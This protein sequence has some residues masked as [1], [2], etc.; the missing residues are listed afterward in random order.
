LALPLRP[1]GYHRFHTAE[2]IT[3]CAHPQLSLFDKGR[4]NG[5]FVR[6]R[7]AHPRLLKC[8]VPIVANGDDIRFGSAYV[9]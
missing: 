1:P 9:F 5:D 6:F 8:M 2:H 4:A 3:L 7:L